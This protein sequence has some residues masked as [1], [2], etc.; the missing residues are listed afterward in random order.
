MV[1]TVSNWQDYF[2]FPVFGHFKN[3]QNPLFQKSLGKKNLSK[4]KDLVSLS[5]FLEY[6]II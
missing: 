2:G 4:L 5:Y 1:T 3:V 6:I